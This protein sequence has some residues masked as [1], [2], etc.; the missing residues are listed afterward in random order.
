M[1]SK[2]PPYV[3]CS[4]VNTS[5]QESSVVISLSSQAFDQ[6]ISGAKKAAADEPV[7]ITDHGQPTHVL[8]TI[9]AYRALT[10]QASIIDML[11]MPEGQDIDF[12]PPQLTSPSRNNHVRLT[13][14]TLVHGVLVRE[15]GP[16]R[17]AAKLLARLAGVSPWTADNWLQGLCAPRGDELLRLM[18][19]CKALR[20]EIMAATEKSENDPV[21]R[22]GIG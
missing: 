5:D 4:D 12:D 2:L 21:Y 18:T 13:Y 3:H 19:E 9:A 20:N 14:S 7:F 10:G 15:F 17:N 1:V 16:L 11:A 8:L 6:D 22:P